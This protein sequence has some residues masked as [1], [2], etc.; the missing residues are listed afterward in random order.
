VS[1]SS[2]TAWQNRQVATGRC[3][4]CG[5][6]AAKASPGYCRAHKAARAE[7]DAAVART[8]VAE[9][10]CLDCGKDRNNETTRCDDCR[11]ARVA[12]DERYRLR[13]RAG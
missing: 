13:T 9:S 5:R 1:S 12:R 2:A 11:A 6:P 4:D 10:L 7:R 8:R 3:R